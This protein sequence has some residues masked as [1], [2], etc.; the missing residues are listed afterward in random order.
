MSDPA[1]R[2]I[3]SRLRGLPTALLDGRW[4]QCAVSV[5]DGRIRFR[6]PARLGR[7]R[8]AQALRRRLWLMA[9]AGAGL[10]LAY[11]LRGA[12]AGAAALAGALLFLFALDGVA[13]DL[14][15]GGRVHEYAVIDALRGEVDLRAPGGMVITTPLADI[16]GFLMVVDADHR[17]CHLGVVLEGGMFLPWLTTGAPGS[18]NALTWLFGHLTERPA[19]RVFGSLPL[20]DDWMGGA[21][22]IEPPEA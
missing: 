9:G 6:E 22:L 2:D 17:R 18:C 14:R 4:T 16:R 15:R 7:L 3:L 19:L 21:E 5:I 20:S 10:L 8:R 13:A 12:A 1:A 11:A